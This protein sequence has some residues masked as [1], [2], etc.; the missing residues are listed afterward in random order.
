[1]TIMSVLPKPDPN[2]IVINPTYSL[3]K[4]IPRLNAKFGDGWA[5]N[6]GTHRWTTSDTATIII[7]AADD[8]INVTLN[9]ECYPLNVNNSLS[10]YLNGEKINTDD[11]DGAFL[12]NL[13]LKKG[14]NIIEF[15]A[16][17]PPE[18][19]NNG[20][21]RYLDYMFKLIQIQEVD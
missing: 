12:F 17:L 7:N 9:L 5:N 16:K 8:N 6:E 18:S 11:S 19:P 15:K 3:V 10:V 2:T 1:M 21:P 4:G 14:D 13:L 20:D